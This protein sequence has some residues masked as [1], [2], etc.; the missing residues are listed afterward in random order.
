MGSRPIIRVV[1]DTNVIVSALLFG[2]VPGRLVPHW[3]IGKVLP[4]ISREIVD[5]YLRVL[6]YPKFGLNENEIEYLLYQ[7]ILPYFEQVS[8]GKKPAVVQA[9]PSDDKFLHCAAAAGAECI[10]SGDDHLLDLREYQG[11]SILTVNNFLSIL[12]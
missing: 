11:I 9:D 2:G 6:A 10:V 12:R 3:K 7:E 1:I 5:E 8:I 4:C